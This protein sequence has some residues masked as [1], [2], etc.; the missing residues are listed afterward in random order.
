MIGKY[1]KVSWKLVLLNLGCPRMDINYTFLEPFIVINFPLNT[2]VT[3]LAL[4]QLSV[5]I[6]F[7]I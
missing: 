7:I 3:V 4:S 1:V 6:N 5:A 2:N